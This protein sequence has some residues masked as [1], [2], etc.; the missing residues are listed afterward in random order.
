MKYVLIKPDKNADIIFFKGVESY[1]DMPIG[2]VYLS[3]AHVFEYEPDV[4]QYALDKMWQ[5][6]DY[7]AIPIQDVDIFKAKLARK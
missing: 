6:S 7:T 4:M 2:T 1:H 5:L 3:N